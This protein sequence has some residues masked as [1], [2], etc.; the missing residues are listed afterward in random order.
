[1]RLYKKEAWE[2]YVPLLRIQALGKPL[3]K[4]VGITAPRISVET[5][6]PSLVF[7]YEVS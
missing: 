7:N 2:L 4:D 6:T 5:I 3:K 1:M